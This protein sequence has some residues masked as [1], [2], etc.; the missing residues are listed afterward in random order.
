VYRSKPK[1]GTSH[2]HAYATVY[3]VR[4]GRRFTGALTPVAKGEATKT[5]LQRLLRQAARVG[6][7]PRY[8]L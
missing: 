1:S 3:V 4:K 7:R 6:I 2:F 8:L 5:V